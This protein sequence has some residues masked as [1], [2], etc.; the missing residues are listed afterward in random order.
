MNGEYE[1]NQESCAWIYAYPVV[2][3]LILM[4][5]EVKLITDFFVGLQTTLETI[6]NI[7]STKGRILF[8][9]SQICQRND[10]YPCY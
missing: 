3:S 5:S 1:V 6:S 8:Y 7:V 4:M 9:F 10:Q 2:H